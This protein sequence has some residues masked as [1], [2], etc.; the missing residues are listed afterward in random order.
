MVF[1]D[2]DLA[3]RLERIE[4]WCNSEHARVR[5]NVRPEADT[6]LVEVAGGYASF[7]G[8]GAPLTEAKGMGMTGPVSADDFEVMERVFFDRGVTAKVMVCPLADPSLLQGLASRGYRASEFEDVLYRV[9]DPGE[10]FPGVPDGI[11]LGWA[12]P[13]EVA[14]CGETLAR[15]FFAPEEPSEE[16]LGL[17]Q[18][19]SQVEGTAGLLARVN[20]EP[21]G[22]ASL[23]IRDGLAMLGGAA[24]LPIYRNRGIQTALSYTRLNFASKTGCDLAVVG[25]SPGSTSHRNAE[26]LGFRVAYT[27]LALVR[28][29]G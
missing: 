19:S 29:P 14:V 13:D 26:R 16:I 18:L 28:D 5:Q 10:E 8:V 22:A 27:K 4:A 23:L 24:T 17:F 11:A 7:M 21:A 9:L 15:G 20:G 1:V 3:R 25:A 6:A 12:S 2:L